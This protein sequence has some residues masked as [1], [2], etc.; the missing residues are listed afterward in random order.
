MC[1]HL[2]SHPVPA[3]DLIS[4]AKDTTMKCLVEQPPRD[5]R[6]NTPEF[7]RSLVCEL[8]SLCCELSAA[9][10][11][12]ESIGYVFLVQLPASCDLPPVV[13]AERDGT[14][15]SCLD[16]GRPGEL[17]V[18]RVLVHSRRPND[19]GYNQPLEDLFS[20]CNSVFTNQEAAA[21]TPHTNHQPHAAAHVH[22][23]AMVDALREG[24]RALAE[25]YTRTRRLQYLAGRHDIASRFFA[26][27]R[28]GDVAF[29]SR[30]S[31]EPTRSGE[32][33]VFELVDRMMTPSGHRGPDSSGDETHGEKA[34]KQTD[35]L[36]IERLRRITSIGQ[37]LN[38]KFLEGLDTGRLASGKKRKVSTAAVARATDKKKMLCSDEAE[39]PPM[40]LA[41]KEQSPPA[42]DAVNTA[43]APDAVGK[44]RAAN[45][46]PS[47]KKT[48]NAKK[49]PATKK[50]PPTK[51]K[52]TRDA[53]HPGAGKCAEHD[54]II[55]TFLTA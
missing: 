34:G 22:M 25:L 44:P 5:Y 46:T 47:T 45:K 9:A 49:A 32:V 1:I 37:Q 50:A 26:F 36:A 7:V 14:G 2:E 54:A 6:A 53:A 29:Y 27:A 15:Y 4:S 3:A 39:A 12:P 30:G 10:S 43:P 42:P 52:K 8:S 33:D 51:K 21:Y 41:E 31:I 23:D 19:I 35:R 38:K 16:T 11:R 18:C 28:G 20:V 24:D 13:P 40:A 17:G 55:A 48:P